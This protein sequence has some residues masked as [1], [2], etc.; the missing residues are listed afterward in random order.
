MA[1]TDPAGDDYL[2]HPLGSEGRNLEESY[3][4]DMAA[5]HHPGKACLQDP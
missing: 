2:S 5:L 3:T 4:T 1:E